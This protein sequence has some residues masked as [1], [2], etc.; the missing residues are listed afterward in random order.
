M[1][2]AH[3]C[4]LVMGPGRQG[5]MM[6]IVAMVPDGI[7]FLS[8]YPS[9]LWQLTKIGI[10]RMNEDPAA[11]QSWVTQGS[12]EKMLNTFSEFPSWLTSIFK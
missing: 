7:Y 6:G 9:F 8:A 4:R 3:D 11:G 12:M 1:V 10:E 5:E 2:V